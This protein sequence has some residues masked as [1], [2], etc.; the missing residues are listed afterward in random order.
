MKHVLRAV[1]PVVALLAASPTAAWAAAEGEPGLFS[2]NLGL[3]IWTVVVFI[4]LVLLLRKFA[5]GPIL[6]AVEAREQRIQAVLD[7]SA[8]QRDEAARMLDE[9]KRQLADARRQASEVIAEG[10]AAGERIRKEIEEKA[11]ADAQGIVDAALR[12]IERERDRALAELRKESVDLALAAAAKLMHERLDDARD[13]ELVVNYL[14]ELDETSG[15]AQ[16]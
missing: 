13:R 2:I 15:G 16:A 11:R 1:L 7:E 12:E 5:W 3:S 6:G 10:K 9:H 14:Q 8:A 4:S